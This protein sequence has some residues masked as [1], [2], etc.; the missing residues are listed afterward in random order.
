MSFMSSI[1]R[2]T[3][4]GRIRTPTVLALSPT[5][6]QNPTI[7]RAVRNHVTTPDG[8][9]ETMQSHW[10]SQL[11]QDRN[12]ET[13][14]AWESFRSHREEV[15]QLRRLRT[16]DSPPRSR[17]SQA[18]VL[19]MGWR[20]GAREWRDDDPSL[21]LTRNLEKSQEVSRKNARD[22]RDPVRRRNH[23]PK[24]GVAIRPVRRTAVSKGI[25]HPGCT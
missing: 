10:M 13:Q 4:N 1:Q 2:C 14:D 5:S 8:V 20:E 22:P 24:C 17:R 16:S 6:I 12:R 18:I 19:T 25:V 23:R 15:M 3:T 11:Q 7:S 21:S 9:F